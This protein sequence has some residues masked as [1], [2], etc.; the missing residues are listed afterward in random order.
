M[1]ATGV[2]M[3]SHRIAQSTAGRGKPAGPALM[4]GILA[5]AFILT[6][7]PAGAQSGNGFL[8]SEPRWTLSLR[9]GLDRAVA[10][11]DIFSF[12]TDQLTLEKRDFGGFTY[13]ADLAYAVTPRVEV[14]FGASYVRSK[15]VSEFREYVGTDD[16]P[17]SQTTT[18]S[19]L[20]VTATVKAYLNPRGRSIGSLAWV[21]TRFSP[22]VGLGAGIVYYDLLQEGEFVEEEEGAEFFEVFYDRFTSSGSSATAHGV[23]GADFALSPRV[24][25]T[26]QGRYNWANA[27]MNSVDFIGFDRIDLSGFSATMGFIVRF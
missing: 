26:T 17:I 10:G 19:R 11:S 4:A 6:A 1:P 8:F 23:V 15:R 13:G 18:F 24:G 25:I 20:P 2:L 22:F 21:P 12:F 16:L 7:S 9:G 5:L 27:D 3:M 14:A